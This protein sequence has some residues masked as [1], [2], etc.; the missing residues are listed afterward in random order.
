[1]L[2]AENWKI[3]L[4]LYGGHPIPA[5]LLAYQLIAIKKCL[6]R[7]HKG[8]PDA[9]SGLNLAIDGLTLTLTSTG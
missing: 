7:G 3:A 6:Q 5:L 1:M 4:R 9:I 8:I 2:E